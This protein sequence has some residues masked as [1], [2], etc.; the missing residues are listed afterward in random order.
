[1][2]RGLSEVF[3]LDDFSG[4]A[5]VRS[6]F[7]QNTFVTT[8]SYINIALNFGFHNYVR[9]KFFISVTPHALDR[10]PLSQTVTPSRTPSPSS[11]TSFMD[12]PLHV[13]PRKSII[14]VTR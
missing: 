1:M 6:P 12:G 3:C 13:V 8:E 14:S 4:V 10:L 11:V 5:F 7:C 9:F 2:S